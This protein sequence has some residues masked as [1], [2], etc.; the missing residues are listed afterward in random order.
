MFTYQ[1]QTFFPSKFEKQVRAM[2][3]D[4]EDTGANA[5]MQIIDRL[6]RSLELNKD[7]I[8]SE[9]ARISAE[10]RSASLLNALN[11]GKTG[12]ADL[13]LKDLTENELNKDEFTR[14]NLIKKLKQIEFFSLEESAV[15]IRRADWLDYVCWQPTVSIHV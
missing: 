9:M 12:S 8:I 11:V 3:F 4:W 13:T 1:L 2:T 5:D 6:T 15:K 10:Q 14:H 7:Q